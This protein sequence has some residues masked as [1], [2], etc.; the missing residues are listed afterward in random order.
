MSDA[1]LFIVFVVMCGIAFVPA[2]LV[3]WAI[4]KIQKWRKS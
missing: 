2:M 1:N 3:V 4:Q